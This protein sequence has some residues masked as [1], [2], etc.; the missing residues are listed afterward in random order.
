MAHTIYKTD[1]L[2]LG[3]T[4]VGE[5]HQYL[6]L[7]TRALGLVWALARSTREERSKLRYHVQPC[8][9]GE[10]A[11]V[12]GKDLWRLTGARGTWNGFHDLR[13]H[14][15]KLALFIRYLSLLKRL[16]YGEGEQRELFSLLDEAI[17]FLQ[18]D[19]AGE[20]LLQNFE[21]LLALR[22][23]YLLGYLGEQQKL[24]GILHEHTFD[25]DVLGRV[26]P[27]RQIAQTEIRRALYE[28]QL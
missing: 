27:L 21:C 14:P 6:A 16:L 23:L 13:T 4:G 10:F 3:S 22:T 9:Y 7:F 15:A 19:T 26:S 25:K 18:G 24:S 17:A 12:R 5:S 20:D 11:L 1:A 28:S 8:T 2:V